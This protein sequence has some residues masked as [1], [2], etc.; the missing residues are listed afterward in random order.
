MKFHWTPC[1]CRWV[2][3]LSIWISCKAQTKSNWKKFA[4][5]IYKFVST[6][7]INKSTNTLSQLGKTKS[8]L[9]QF[10]LKYSQKISCL[11]FQLFS[12]KEKLLCFVVSEFSLLTSELY[13]WSPLFCGLSIKN[14]KSLN[15]PL[16]IQLKPST[17]K[18]RQIYKARTTTHR[19]S[20]AH[21]T[22]TIP[23]KSV[24]KAIG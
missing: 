6:T 10:N 22:Q 3:I 24:A 9:I 14:N 11:H 5:F 16:K 23:H 2:I 8:I 4:E 21:N 17:H 1:Y 19:H 12:W 20:G 18:R 15:T 13:H 7:Y